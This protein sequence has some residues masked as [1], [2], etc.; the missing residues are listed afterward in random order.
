MMGIK[1]KLNGFCAES[2]GGLENGVS[3]LE[4]ANAYATIANG[5][6]RNRPRVIKKIDHPRRQV[7]AAEA[8]ARAPRQGLRGR[9]HLRGDQ[10]PRAERHRR[11]RRPRRRSAARRAAR[12][13]RRTRTST[14]GSSASRRGCRPPSGSASPAAR[15]LDERHVRADRRQHRRRHVSGRH[16]GRLHEQ[17]RR[18][19]LRQVQAARP[20]RSRASRSSATTRAQA[21]RGRRQGPGADATNDPSPSRRRQP[22][23]T[24][25]TRRRRQ[26][27][28]RP[29]TPASNDDRLRPRAYETQPQDAPATESPAAA[30]R[31][32]PTAAAA[33]APTGTTCA[34]RAARAARWY[35]GRQ[36][37]SRMLDHEECCRDGYRC[38]EVVQRREGLR[39]HHAR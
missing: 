16:L 18:Q 35:A 32:P 19:V 1:S 36:C 3:P 22:T 20:S 6:Y 10:D 27:R 29:K 15:D 37:H 28:Q 8:L 13:A 38:R 2:L 33:A 9:R 24:A 12:P 25:E 34:V 30:R 7:R 23:R 11:H 4:M 14:P 26:R 17:G 21:R 39:L 5:G 31:R